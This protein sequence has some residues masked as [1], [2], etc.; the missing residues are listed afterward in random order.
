MVILFKLVQNKVY[1]YE[2]DRASINEVLNLRQKQKR[3]KGMNN[4]L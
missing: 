3:S 4:Q 2:N 1:V